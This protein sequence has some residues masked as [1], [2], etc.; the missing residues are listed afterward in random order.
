MP[1]DPT[2]ATVVGEVKDKRPEPGP[3]PDLYVCTYWAWREAQ[4]PSERSEWRAITSMFHR[5]L[6]D[7]ED[8]AADLVVEGCRNVRIIKIPGDAAGGGQG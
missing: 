4:Y 8:E 5:P 6:K 3:F 2:P 7:I 1:N